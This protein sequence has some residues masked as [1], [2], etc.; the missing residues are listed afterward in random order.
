MKLYHF[1]TKESLES[2]KK[3]G[4]TL[5]VIPV[6]KGDQVNVSQGFQWLT[7]N[8][9]FV[10][11]WDQGN[12]PYKRTDCRITVKIP[13]TNESLIKWTDLCNAGL[14]KETAAILNSFGDP[15]NW[16]VYKGRIK[17]NY[18]REVLCKKE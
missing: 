4:L 17:P 12:L 10:Q 11:E 16:Y 9:S 8:P 6:I 3:E 13:K 7:S 1:C 18:F 14:L 2:I 5:G 15:E